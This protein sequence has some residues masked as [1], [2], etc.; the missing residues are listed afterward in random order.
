MKRGSF[1]AGFLTGLLVVG[2]TTTA[3]ATG[4]MAERSHHRVVVDGKGVQMEAYR[5]K[6]NNYVKLRD[7]GEAVGFEV[8]WDSANGCVQVGGHA[9]PAPDAGD[10]RSKRRGGAMQ[11]VAGRE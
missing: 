6:G 4:I 5:I 11:R 1:A 8:Y 7:M 10:H 2:V 9:M 3:Y